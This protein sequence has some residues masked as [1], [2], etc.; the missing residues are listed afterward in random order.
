MVASPVP[1]SLW[2]IVH[3]FA[4]LKIRLVRNE[5]R[6]GVGARAGLVLSWFAAV[7]AGLSGGIVL[8]AIDLTDDRAVRAFTLAGAGVGLGCVV[9]PAV[10]LGI[11]E[12]IGPDHLRPFAL[13]RRQQVAGLLTAAAI[14]PVPLAGLL[15]LAGAV[16]GIARLTAAALPTLVAGG[17]VLTYVAGA[18]AASRLPSVLLSRLLNSRRG[19]DA[20]LVLASL[21]GVLVY[22]MQYVVRAADRL[23]EPAV[24]RVAGVAR[25]LPPGALGRSLGLAAA[26]E[27]AAAARWLAMGMAGVAG[28]LVVWSFAMRRQLGLAPAPARTRRSPAAEPLFDGLSAALPRTSIGA[29]AARELRYQWRDPRR[30]VQAITALV[31]GLVWPVLNN[32]QHG[33]GRSAT[34]LFATAASWLVVFGATN[35]FGLDGRAAWFDLS[36]SAGPRRLFLGRNLALFVPGFLAASVACLVLGALTGGWAYVPA[37]LAVSAAG[38]VAG[39]G[40]ANVASVVAPMPVPEGSNPLSSGG[41]GRGCLASLLYGAALVGLTVLLAPLVVAV[42]VHRDSPG[43]CLVVGLIGL[44]CAAAVW[45]VL[46]ALASRLLRS[47]VPEVLGAVDPR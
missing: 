8:A 33:R 46:T 34:V 25:W 30:R 3:L 7:V 37:A 22:A 41:Q 40:G 6:R 35:Q 27:A 2:R 42:T 21:L 10:V 11:S 31:M 38:M 15:V 43:A 14:G 18:L 13:T 12:V 5:W 32:L 9:V 26:G 28:V 20:A 24:A 36:S 4:R 23:S 16:V 17:A 1:L 45:W 47:R 39:L 29:V 19:R 44:P